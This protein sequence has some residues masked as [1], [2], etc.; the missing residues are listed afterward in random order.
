MQYLGGMPKLR[1]AEQVR[2]WSMSRAYEGFVKVRL[3]VYQGPIEQHKPFI[4]S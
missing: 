1:K 2:E 4:T 3:D